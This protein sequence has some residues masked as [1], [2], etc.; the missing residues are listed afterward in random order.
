MT[1]ARIIRDLP[2]AE[3]REITG[4]G[5]WLEWRGRDVTASRIDALFDE[6]PYL[7]RDQLAAEMRGEKG[8]P[9]NSAMRAGNI[10]EAGFPFALQQ[11]GKSW[12]VIKA[13]TYHRLP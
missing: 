10:L 9:P 3:G 5:E 12:A 11:D 6:H 2:M 8:E 7:S 13:T 4:R 1:A